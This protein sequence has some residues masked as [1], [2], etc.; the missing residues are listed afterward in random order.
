MSYNEN[1]KRSSIRTGNTKELLSSFEWDFEFVSVPVI[2][3][4]FK[5]EQLNKL[6]RGRT[7]AVQVPEDPQNNIMSVMI[8][9]HRFQQIGDVPAYGQFVITVQDF[10]DLT[11]QQIF[12][13]LTY[14]TSDPE[15]KKV[16]GNPNDYLFDMRIKR[17]DPTWNTVKTWVCHDCLVQMA[18]AN[19]S[20]TG[21]KQPVGSTTISFSVDQYTIEFNKTSS[22]SSMY[23]FSGD[24]LANILPTYDE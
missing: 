6:M 21:D 5:D 23:N 22:D 8:H 11:I 14:S 1:I 17:M 7:L 2:L 3:S 4:Q 13:K 12:T 9:G 16:K 20:M 18:D 19:E 15:T 24:T 10:A